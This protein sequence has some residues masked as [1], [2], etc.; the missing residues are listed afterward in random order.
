MIYLDFTQAR[1]AR[2]LSGLTRVGGRLAAALGERARP[3]RWSEVAGS[4]RPEDWFLTSELFSEEERPGFSAFL[5]SRPCRMA[6]IYHDAIPLKFPHTTWSKSV[7]R[8]PHY[9]SLLSRF[10]RVW[11]VSRASREEL[12]GYWKWQGVSGPEVG[13]IDLGADM[14]DNARVVA[15]PLGRTLLCVGILEPRK[16]QD[17]LLSACE[18]LWGEGLRFDLVL[19]GRV[20]PQF[21]RPLKRR[22][23]ALARRFPQ[24]SHLEGVDD[25]RLVGLYADARAT[26][27]PTLAEGC[28]LPL[29]ESLWMGVPC[30]CSDVAPVA[31]NARGGGCKVVPAGDLDAWVEALRAIVSD[32]SLCAALAGAARTRPLPT[33]AQAADRLCGELA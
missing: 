21:G 20:N 15:G 1:S 17:L 31:E 18:R 19:V 22:V 30:V 9:L 24:L 8:H 23:D 25:A 4:A 27:M 11:A 28:G 14:A 6:A 32:D 12:L 29:L 3:V 16:N 2:H 26:L 33:W 7:A 13:V 5:G 10:N